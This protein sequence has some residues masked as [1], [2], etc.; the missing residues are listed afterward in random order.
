M[1]TIVKILISAVVIGI[2]TEVAKKYPAQGGI[3]AALPLVTI[4]SII[5][6]SVQG[7]SSGTIST[8]LLGVL[9]GL[10]ATI[11]L[12]LIVYI[13]LQYSIHLMA[14]LLLGICGWG[15]FLFIQTNVVKYM[16]SFF[17]H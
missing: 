10:P 8:F 16:S 2:V 12:V 7:E 17:S 1:Y 5:W 9:K 11:I 3:I 13:A 15:L 4:L 6:L 14:A